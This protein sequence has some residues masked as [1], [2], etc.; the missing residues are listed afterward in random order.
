M[1]PNEMITRQDLLAER[2]AWAT[3]EG[4]RH[5]VK[6]LDGVYHLN[7]KTRVLVQAIDSTKPFTDH[8]AFASD[9]GWVWKEQ[10]TVEEQCTHQNAYITY[11]EPDDKI[12]KC[13]DCGCL[14]DEDGI[15]VR[16]PNDEIP[17]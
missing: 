6:L 10:L 12:L 9:T 14:T 16:Y 1:L 5:P 17:Y 7:N 15:I 3:I 13:P 4:V 11:N 2:K 8:Q